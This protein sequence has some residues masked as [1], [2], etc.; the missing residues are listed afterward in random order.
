MSYLVLI[1]S[2]IAL[3]LILIGIMSALR[4]IRKSAG[5]LKFSLVFV[6]IA[7][8]IF[9]IHQIGL[10]FFLD[11]NSLWGGYL[12]DI[13]Y[14]GIA[15][16]LL[17]TLIKLEEIILGLAEKQDSPRKAVQEQRKIIILR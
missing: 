1:T 2:S 8:V 11:W 13:I 17:L 5:K 4:T 12:L 3:L 9:G 15:L 10:I 16:F 6:V 7:L 14:I